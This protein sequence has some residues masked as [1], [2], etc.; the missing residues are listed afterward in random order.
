MSVI[1]EK[2]YL[3]Y[4][5]PP[6]NKGIITIKGR[7]VNFANIQFAKYKRV[8]KNSILNNFFFN[9]KTSLIWLYLNAKCIS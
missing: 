6:S 8:N 7:L 2:C 4:F 1:S 5:S 3:A 9:K